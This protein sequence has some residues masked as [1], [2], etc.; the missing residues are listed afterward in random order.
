MPAGSDAYA[1]FRPRAARWVAW[2]LLVLIGVAVAALLVLSFTTMEGYGWADRILTV[3]FAGAG[4]VIVYRQ[5][6]T[7][8]EE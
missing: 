5:G 2:F 7:W 6:I 3:A 8:S 1:P 4:A